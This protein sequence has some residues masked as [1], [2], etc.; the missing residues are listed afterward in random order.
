MID[1]SGKV[2]TQGLGY[3]SQGFGDIFREVKGDL[4]YKDPYELKPPNKPAKPSA[5][6]LSVDFYPVGRLQFVTRILDKNLSLAAICKGDWMQWAIRDAIRDGLS[7]YGKSNLRAE[8]VLFI[9]D[10]P[11]EIVDMQMP[12]MG[13]DLWQFCEV[14]VDFR[15][16]TKTP[17]QAEKMVDAIFMRM[18]E[19][20]AHMCKSVEY[21]FRDIYP[22]TVL[23]M[24]HKRFFLQNGKYM[25]DELALFQA[26]A[27][28]NLDEIV[29]IASRPW[30]DVNAHQCTEGCPPSFVPDEDLRFAAVTLG[31]TALL[32]AA[33]E[34][35]LEAMRYLMDKKANVHFQDTSGFHALYLAAGVPD[36]GQKLVN[37]LLAWDAD[38]NL[39]N[40]SGYT[41]LHNACGSG[42][43][44]SVR[45]LLENRGDLN[46]KSKSGAAPVHAAVLNNQP[47]VLD[48]LKELKANL[49]MPAFGGNTPVHEGVMQNNPSIIQ[50]LFD[51]NAD[52]NIESGPEH[53]F[54]TPLKMATDRKKKKAAKK[55]KELG[56]LERIEHEYEE[57]SEGEFQAIGDGEYAPRVK[58]RIY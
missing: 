38:V 51:L 2:G 44:D 46:L 27:A 31:R 28:N 40:K 22:I 34:G 48:V 50:K 49:D 41:P 6:D 45:A 55:L 42:A 12:Y 53:G 4:A 30:V 17:E 29:D 54:A 16:K 5:E 19:N 52:I 1:G 3:V 47:E 15:V 13:S 25:S 58:G 36:A 8:H 11:V 24:K 20:E 26:A 10:P 14:R 39:A 18:V 43:C 56:A 21:T 35:H 37:F 33:E 32:A 57:S 9:N 7:R 23:E